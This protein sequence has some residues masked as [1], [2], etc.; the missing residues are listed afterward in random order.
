MPGKE[1]F[2]TNINLN[3]RHHKPLRFAFYFFS[4]AEASGHN[5]KSILATSKAPSP[6]LPRPRKMFGTTCTM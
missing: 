4:P 1:F 3:R 6:P 2:S 5:P